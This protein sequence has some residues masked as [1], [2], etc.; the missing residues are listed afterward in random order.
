MNPN[1]VRILLF[2]AFFLS[3]S[4]GLIYQTVWV[5]M[6]TRYLG[7]TTYATATVLGV[8]MLGLA[9][10]S[11][12]GGK[13]AD[14]THR[15]IGLYCLLEILIAALSPFASLALI[16]GLGPLYLSWAQA[17]S[18]DA[19]GL[20]GVRVLFVAICLLPPTIL[21]G[22]T[23]PVLV[24]FVTRLSQQ[25]QQG[26][27]RM[28]AV[29]T[30]GAVAGV[31]AT[32]LVLLGELGESVSLYSAATLN[33]AAAVLACML[34]GQEIGIVPQRPRPG[35][36]QEE[37]TPFHPA[38]R[39]LA[40]LTFFVSGFSALAYEILWSRLL[41]LVLETSI[42][43]FS[44]MLAV[45][46]LGI[47]W[48]SWDSTRSRRMIQRPVTAFARLEM[49]IGAWAAMGL[50]LLPWFN[51]LWLHAGGGMEPMLTVPL[52]IGSLACLA[53]VLPIA[54][55][56]GMQFPVAVRCCVA[57]P[58]APG[59]S[60]GRA[61]LVNTLG[62]VAG[63]LLTG[64]LLIP[65]LGTAL[66]LVAISALNLL[67]GFV[68]A[69][70]AP[71]EQRSGWTML[72]GLAALGIVGTAFSLGD[73]YPAMITT[74]LKKHHGPGW[75]TFAAFE[76]ATAT[77]IAAGDRAEPTAR[78]L[79]VNGVGMTH[80]CTETKL[81]A[82]LPHA[83]AENP[84]R[85]CVICFGMGTTVRSAARYGDLQ[86]DAVDIVPEV[87]DCFRFFH[88]D[89]ERIAAMPNVRFHVDDGRNYLLVRP[90]LYD[91]ITIDPAPP[92]HSAGTV[93][94]YTEEF[95]QLCRSRLTTGGVFCLWV[96]PAAESEI[97]MIFRSFFT[98]FP[99]VTLWG[100]HHTPGFYLMGKHQPFDLR[101]EALDRLAQTLM[102]HQDDL[103]E[104]DRHYLE[105]ERFKQMLLM[106]REALREWLG[107][108]PRVTDDHP[109]TE[110]PLWRQW[111]D[112]AGHR[113]LD[114][115]L[116][117]EKLQRGLKKPAPL[118]P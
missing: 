56:F 13:L 110:F 109:R 64:F 55:L 43:A 53:M 35:Q 12:L 37:L 24:A 102:Q 92:L 14:R 100:A 97:L 46:L 48:G 19:A 16:D 86:I 91:V 77:T 117:R 72:L 95:F 118:Q 101:P 84:K 83:L 42:Y 104:W 45:F 112:P 66:T 30:F 76:R 9:I 79:L 103:R 41:V 106:D 85:M 26:L 60:T 7:A 44:L 73:P 36:D 32:G 81:M 21:M 68:L 59:Q 22:A 20:L 18:H 99:H 105:P 28:Y 89:A 114:A 1:S 57:R 88:A 90:D 15:L 8:F 82:H 70:A 52:V 47:A 94:L 29:N 69:L 75:E 39:G 113:R 111:F 58:D 4:S 34:F 74:R 33:L 5:R 11:F 38:L 71:R 3:G 98:A 27:G 78:T 50:V 115:N 116:L 80:L 10:G 96:P 17:L 2:L 67:L 49:G 63:S 65:L 23:L 61:Y 25:F 54:F 87:F 62:T 107:S 6:L 93:N 40:L 51:G 31:L 108:E